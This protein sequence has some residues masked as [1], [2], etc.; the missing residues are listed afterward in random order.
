LADRE[1]ALDPDGDGYST[2]AEYF[3][4]TDPRLASSRPVVAPWVT[5]RGDAGH[6]GFVPVHIEAGSLAVA[7]S[8]PPIVG[9]QRPLSEVAA[10]DDAAF[11]TSASDCCDYAPTLSRLNAGNGNL[12]WRFDPQGTLY[13]TPPAYARQRV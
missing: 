2:L 10:V 3:A 1:G 11:V 13:L 5:Y 4:Q 12:S 8:R 6:T 7:W 9:D